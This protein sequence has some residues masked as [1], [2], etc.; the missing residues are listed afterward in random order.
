MNCGHEPA[1]FTRMKH[2]A[3]ASSGSSPVHRSAS[4]DCGRSRTSEITG[5][6]RVIRT[7]SGTSA[8]PRTLI[9]S[10]TIRTGSSVPL[11]SAWSRA[12]SFS[13]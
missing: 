12:F 2:S 10:R 13:M 3:V 11:Y 5:P 8:S 4:V 6:C 9:V 1:R 7:R